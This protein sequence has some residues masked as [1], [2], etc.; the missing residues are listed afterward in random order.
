MSKARTLAG[1][2]S[3]GA[4]LADGTV[5]YAEVSGA[6]TAPTGTIVGTTDTQTL[7][8]K[9]IEAAN[10]T[11]ATQFA[12]SSG[13]SGQVL[14]SA[15][16]GAAPTWASPAGGGSMVLISSI[17]ANS[18]GS[19]SFTN[20][21]STY[22]VYVVD[23]V[24]AI[25]VS[26]TVE[27]RMRFSSDNG[28]SYLTSYGYTQIHNQTAASGVVGLAS[29][30]SSSIFF[31]SVTNSSLGGGANGTVKIFNP[32]RSAYTLLLFDFANSAAE[33]AAQQVRGNAVVLGSS[34]KNAFQFLF[35]SGS[36]LSGKFNL[37]G[38]KK[39]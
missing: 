35:S 26:D 28:S 21:D 34:A 24:N 16:S 10:L 20:I 38:I 17:T 12:G 13:T 6:P 29:S 25:P 11:G 15:G 18:S 36:I 30:N 22:D 23:V 37:Y 9:T 14:T 1:T 19:V 5:G 8:N 3:D 4:V 2:V 39:S 31:R 33:D 32:S 7:T 27:L